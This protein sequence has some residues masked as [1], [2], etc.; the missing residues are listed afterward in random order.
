M[1]Q[2]EKGAMVVT[3]VA[4]MDVEDPIVAA[5]SAVG[6]VVVEIIGAEFTA[7]RLLDT[8][9]V[10]T[11]LLWSSELVEKLVILSLL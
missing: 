3:E 2:S 1:G 11:A 5:K 10:T 8:V 4:E 7:G 6:G 9:M